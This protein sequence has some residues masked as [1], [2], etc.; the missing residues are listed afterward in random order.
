M[1]LVEKQW[2]FTQL[3]ARLVWEL[4]DMGYHVTYGEAYRTPDAA[5]LN[6]KQG[7]GIANSLH[8]IR[9]AVDLNLFRQGEFLE[10]VTDYEPAG[11]LWE[12]YSVAGAYQCC[13][14]GRFK[15]LD[16]SHFSIEHEGVR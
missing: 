1:R 12:S 8:I 7:D 11:K 3:V 5:L 6:S 15:S 9:L 4:R 14:G 13:W 10:R 16:A 2:L